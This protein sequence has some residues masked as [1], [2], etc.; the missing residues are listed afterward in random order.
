MLK[1]NLFTLG[2]GCQIYGEEFG[3]KASAKEKELNEQQRK[4]NKSAAT[5]GGGGGTSTSFGG[6]AGIYGPGYGAA[7]SGRPRT[8][9]CRKIS[10]QSGM[11]T[12][13]KRKESIAK[14]DRIH[15]HHGEEAYDGGAA[16][17]RSKSTGGGAGGTA[18]IGGGKSPAQSQGSDT[19]SGGGGRRSATDANAARRSA[20]PADDP[21]KVP[22]Y[23]YCKNHVRKLFHF[24]LA[25]LIKGA[26]ILTEDLF[27]EAIPAAWEM[28][29]EADQELSANA[30]AL[31]IIASVRAPTAASDVMQRALKHR[32][33]NVRIG[34]ILRYQVLWKCRFQVWPRMEDGAH[35][36][37]KVPPPGIE[38]T[39]PSPK[40]GIE[41]LPVVDPPWTPR[42][43]T[44]DMEVTLN[45]ERHVSFCGRSLNL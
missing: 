40:I 3:I 34:A 26:A 20:N 35:I 45:Q 9:R 12:S 10:D 25:A 29:L 17:S 33:A 1:K 41:C 22:V 13:P 7:A 42:T 19:K 36:A 37:F 11:P 32:D 38:F 39:L 16:R 31:F 14:R 24:P 28:L 27:V 18:G 43:K 4:A 30:A 2:G 8:M 23:K 15:S 6:A 21:M 44:K 5:S